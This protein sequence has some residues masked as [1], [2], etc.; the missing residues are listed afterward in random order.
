MSTRHER[1]RRDE[2]TCDDVRPA[3]LAAALVCARCTTP[4][5]D[6]GLCADHLRKRAAVIRGSARRAEGQRAY[7]DRLATIAGHG[8]DHTLDDADVTASPTV[9]LRGVL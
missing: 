4:A 9:A 6:N 2:S 1:A 5:G 3:S 8:R 7:A